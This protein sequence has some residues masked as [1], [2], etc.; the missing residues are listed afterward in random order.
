MCVYV[1]AGVYIYI[2]SCRKKT[3]QIKWKTAESITMARTPLEINRKL[4]T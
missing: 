2:Y 3:S 1:Y 4:N